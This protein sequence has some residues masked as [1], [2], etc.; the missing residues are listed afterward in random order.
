[1]L[2]DDVDVAA[3]DIEMVERVGS[4]LGWPSDAIPRLHPF[5]AAGA[6]AGVFDLG[7]DEQMRAVLAR[8]DVPPAAVDEIVGARPSA[9]ADPEAWWLLER[10]YHTLIDRDVPHPPPPWPA[11]FP[12]ADLFTH[13]FH[14]YAF[15]AAIPDLLRFHARRAIPEHV[16]WRTL[17]DVGLQVANYQT[18]HGRGGFDGAFWVWPHFRGGVYTLGRLQ[19]EAEPA[20]FNGSSPDPINPALGVHIPALGPLDPDAC[21][22]ALAQAVRFFEAHYP[23]T[24]YRIATCESWLLDEQLCD[25]LAPTSN[26]VRFQQRFTAVSD[27]SRVGDEDVLRFVFGRIPRSLDELPQRTSLERAVV[28]HLDAGRHWQFRRGWL[29]L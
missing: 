23:E 1:M 27:W 9:H 3:P 13:Y 22:D 8:L 29:S 11:P 19:F 15:V 17:R 16:T 26:I 28:T 6:P 20:A 18:R 7:D 24:T 21:D 12:S 4:W 25:Y 10:L 5:A 2:A 14:L